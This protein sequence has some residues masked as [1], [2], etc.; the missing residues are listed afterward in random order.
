MATRDVDRIEGADNRVRIH[1]RGG[2]TWETRES[3][4]NL[5]R[6][7]SPR[8]FVRVHRSAIVRVDRIAE[9]QPWFNGDYVLILGDGTR[10]V[11]GRTYRAAVQRLLT[12]G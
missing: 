11:T 1:V 4:A 8:E 9:I 7:L 5:E 3:L 2:G 12:H 6:L 10:V